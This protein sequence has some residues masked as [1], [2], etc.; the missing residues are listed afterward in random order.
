[1]L[2]RLAG[3]NVAYSITSK[4]P[5]ESATGARRG[6]LHGIAILPNNVLTDFAALVVPVLQRAARGE[7]AAVA[8]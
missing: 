7:G 2:K 1:M 4:P 8:G 3:S 6:R 5:F